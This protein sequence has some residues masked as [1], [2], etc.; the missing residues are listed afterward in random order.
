MKNVVIFRWK[1]TSLFFFLPVLELSVV[2]DALAHEVR[3]AVRENLRVLV[4][5]L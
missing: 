2:E 3:H 1:L 4:I 5:Y